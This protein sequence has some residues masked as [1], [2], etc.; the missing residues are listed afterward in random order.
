MRAVGVAANAMVEEVRR[1]FREIDGILEGTAEPDYER[2]IAIST[3]G[4]LRA[5]VAPGLLAMLAPLAMG[6][7]F[8]KAAVGGLLAGSLGAGVLMA[9]FMANAG[10]SW[11]NAKKYVE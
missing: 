11:D 8:G 6:I 2:C 5:M 10:G 4:S 1:Q 9:L 7:I 3:A